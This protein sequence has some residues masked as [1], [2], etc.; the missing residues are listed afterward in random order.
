[1]YWEFLTD[2]SGQPIE[3]HLKEA[4]I[5]PDDGTYRFFGNAGKELQLHA[6]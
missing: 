1:V 6:A 2:V 5:N 3:S 4:K